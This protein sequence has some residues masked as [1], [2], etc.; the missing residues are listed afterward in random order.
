MA[1]RPAT[2]RKCPWGGEEGGERVQAPHPPPPLCPLTIQP[3]HLK[4]LE[5]HSSGFLTR[6]Q[7]SWRQQLPLRR[8]LTKP[9]WWPGADTDLS[10]AVGSERSET[11]DCFSAPLRGIC[12]QA[13]ALSALNTD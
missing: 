9:V 8:K 11:Q 13:C 12:L 7:C 6:S 10:S 1:E 3:P 5:T 4:A 2:L